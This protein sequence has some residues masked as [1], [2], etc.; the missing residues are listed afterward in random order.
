MNQIT[1][2]ITQ[3]LIECWLDT[4]PPEIKTF[5]ANFVINTMRKADFEPE[6]LADDGQRFFANLLGG[7]FE[8][9]LKVWFYDNYPDQVLKDISFSE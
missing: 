5:T 1:I 7:H 8:A 2:P 3:D 9:F 6:K 4:F